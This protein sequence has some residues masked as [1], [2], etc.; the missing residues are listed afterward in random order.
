MGCAAPG[1]A[2][3]RGQGGAPSP[4]PGTRPLGQKRSRSVQGPRPAPP[5]TR[6]RSECAGCRPRRGFKCIPGGR[7]LRLWGRVLPAQALLRGSGCPTA[8][9]TLSPALPA[10]RGRQP[11]ARPRA[12][13][14]SGHPTRAPPPPRSGPRSQGPQS[15]TWRLRLEKKSD[16]LSSLLRLE[17]GSAGNSWNAQPAPLQSTL[18]SLKRSSS[19]QSLCLPLPPESPAQVCKEGCET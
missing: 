11:G 19:H 6:V 7:S 13:G 14:R 16:F 17:S 1:G 4:A 18:V 5:G 2:N 9:G 12:H 10:L 15:P 3:P 8:P